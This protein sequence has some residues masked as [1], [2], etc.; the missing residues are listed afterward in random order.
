MFRKIIQPVLCNIYTSVEEIEYTQTMQYFYIKIETPIR[1][2]WE[3]L[4]WISSNAKQKFRFYLPSTLF[5]RWAAFELSSNHH[6]IQL[7]QFFPTPWGL[8]RDTIFQLGSGPP[9]LV[10]LRLP[11]N[12]KNGVHGFKVLKPK[13]DQR[14]FAM[15]HHPS[16]LFCQMT[17]FMLNNL[18][19]EK[20]TRFWW[21][22]FARCTLGVA[23]KLQPCLHVDTQDLDAVYNE[24]A[25]LW[26]T[27]SYMHGL[28][29]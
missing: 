26:K 27:R 28:L 10:E 11:D 1:N 29:M 17:F 15:L 14:L 7:H 22:K 13:V 2:D 23:I 24:N 3:H 9:S 19:Y 6:Q 8:K 25:S 4:Q 16:C 5:E 18:D 12:T 20:G 21:G